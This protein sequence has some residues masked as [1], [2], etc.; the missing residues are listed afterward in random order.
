M[1]L[2]LYFYLLVSF[3]C[4]ES[5]QGCS[6]DCGD[7]CACVAPEGLHSDCSGFRGCHKECPTGTSILGCTRT[8]TNHTGTD[9]EISDNTDERKIELNIKIN[10]KGLESKGI[11]Y[12]HRLNPFSKL[13][14]LKA[15]K[16][17]ESTC[18]D[19]VNGCIELDCNYRSQMCAKTC[20]L[21]GL[22]A[23]NVESCGRSKIRKGTGYR[24]M[25]IGGKEII[26]HSEP[27]LAMLFKGRRAW[28]HC[29]ATLISHTFAFTAAHCDGAGYYP[30]RTQADTLKLGGHNRKMDDGS[31]LYVP[32]SKWHNHPNVFDFQ[33]K[34]RYGEWTKNSILYWDYS[35]LQ[36]GK[37]VKFTSHIQPACLPSL[38]N[39]DYSGKDAFTS[40][41]GKTEKGSLS[42][43]P[44]TAKLKVVSPKT[45]TSTYGGTR[46]GKEICEKHCQK[47][48]VLCTYGQKKVTFEGKDFVEDACSGDSGGPLV[49]YDDENKAVLI[50]IVSFGY[51]CGKY[52]L[53]AIFSKVD[54]VMQ[55]I[56]G[57]MNQ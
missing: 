35:L 25:I 5:T 22:E 20:G 3:I 56:H 36:L 39:K 46:D 4:I 10:V 16:D 18:K 52:K 21:C 51:D 44:K 9:N 40:G 12:R 50:G 48:D 6:I 13:E 28:T 42:D 32:I 29:G 33:N 34:K 55:W 27:W 45:C 53:P 43:V 24:T 30:K 37:Y 15:K 2:S 41:W 26:P 47:E 14:I 8:L 17:E 23:R 19:E 38:P 49:S 57:I 31:E 54:H 1:Y 7:E 11:D